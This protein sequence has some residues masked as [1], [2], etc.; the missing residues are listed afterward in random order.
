MDKAWLVGSDFERC[1]F[2]ELGMGKNIRKC[3]SIPIELTK[4][5]SHYFTQAPK[6]LSIKQSFRFAQIMG[7]GGNPRTAKKIISTRLGESFQHEDFWV[8]VI[9]FFINNPMLD[10]CHYGPIIDFIYNQKFEEQPVVIEGH[11]TYGSPQPGFSMHKRDPEALLR[12]VERW[13]ERLQ[14]N[15]I[16]KQGYSWPHCDIEDFSIIMGTDHN[17]R[18]WQINQIL[19][20][21]E[22]F[23]EGRALSHCVSSYVGSCA[24]LQTTI[25]SMKLSNIDVVSKNILTI[26][27]SPKDKRIHQIRG[28]FNRG[29]ENEEMNIIS[30]WAAKENLT[31]SQWLY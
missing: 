15:D 19:S 8:S 21:K 22:L 27:M 14:K 4:K 6:E 10:P 9:Q 11:L 16:N 5:M 3:E 30:K 13:H 20:S 17:K 12:Q 25:W 24:R 29:P 26:E 18:I 1:W 23:A 31:I 2:I 28:K 7:I